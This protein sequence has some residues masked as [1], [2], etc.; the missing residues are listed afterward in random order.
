MDRNFSHFSVN[1]KLI[2]CYVILN[3][4]WSY[5]KRVSHL[6]TINICPYGE[7][8]KKCLRYYF[9]PPTNWLADLGVS[10]LSTL[11]RRL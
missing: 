1:E 6:G 11:G 4:L 5:V 7:K 9:F 8:W 2:H 10:K 3:S